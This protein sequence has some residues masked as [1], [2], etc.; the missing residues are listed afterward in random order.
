M[1]VEALNC[2]NCG[3]AVEDES[4]NCTHCRSRLKTM[5]CPAC[6]GTIFE[7]SKFCGIC[8]AVAVRPSFDE[9]DNRNCPRCKVKMRTLNVEGIRID[10]CEKCE[11]AWTD[12]ETFEAI[13]INQESQN[14]VLSKLD[15]IVS[16]IKHEQV[17][18]VPCP[19][20]EQLMNR[21][22][23]AKVSGVIIDSCRQHGI[24]FDAMELP[25]IINF[26]RMGGM[27]HARQKA[28]NDLE[29]ERQ[30]LSAERFRMSVD[31]FREPSESRTST[32]LTTTALRN[33]IESI[34]D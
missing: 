26:I 17:R 15:E 10:E 23:F 32:G 27:N 24:W 20:C 2:P 21:S 25:Q 5:S 16:K 3:A 34:F 14:A 33:F 13:C 7:G 11:G 22:N 28:L 29:S 18:Y 12:N 8:G 1:K 30:K 31:R 4:T 9:V 6:L 19:V